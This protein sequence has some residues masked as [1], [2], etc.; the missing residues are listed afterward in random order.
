MFPDKYEIGMSHQGVKI[1]YHLL[2]KIEGVNVE[3]A[4]L[5]D[6]RSKDIFL[7][8]KIPL[9]SLE[10]RKYLKDFDL[11]GFSILS[12]LSFTNILLTLELSGIPLKTS[13]RG[14]KFPVIAIGGISAAANPEPVRD[15]VD[16][17][18]IGDGEVLF[19]E[20][21]QVLKE[22]KK[23]KTGRDLTYFDKL[24]GIYVPSLYPLK[25]MGRFYAPEVLSGTIKKRIIKNLDNSFKNIGMIVPLTEVVFNRLET[26][27][28]RG[29]PQNC[30]F[31]QAKAYYSPFRIKESQEIKKEYEEQILKTGF[32]SMSL[33]SL[34]SGDHP[35]IDKLVRD[36]VSLPGPC[37]SV[38]LPSLRPSTLSESML[39]S[40][41][42]F[43]KTGITIVPEAGSP[44]LR[45]VVNKNVTDEEILEAVKKLISSG[46]QKIKL[47]FMLGLPSETDEDIAGI[48]VLVETIL[49]ISKELKKWIKINLSFSPFIPK[50]HTAFQWAGRERSEVIFK[51]IEF[52]KEN[53][54][55]F[56]NVKFDFHGINKGVVETILARGDGRVGDLIFDAFRAGEIFT[57][58]D[59]KFNYSIWESLIKKYD[60]EI[61][62]EEIPVK[63]VLPWD[64]IELGFKRSY[65]ESEYKR[66][67][68][69]I[70][71]LSCLDMK[72]SECNGCN[73]KFNKFPKKVYINDVES[74]KHI[75]NQEE[76]KRIRIFYK[77][78]NE[79]RYF[80][81]LSMMK[82]IERI[83]RKTG[84]PFRCTEGHHPRI[85]MAS[86]P[87][88]PVFASGENEVVELFISKNV[89]LE[90]LLKELQ[91]Q[92]EH[93][94][95]NNVTEVKENKKKLTK[96]IVYTIY[97]YA[98]K[99]IKEDREI[100][101]RLADEKDTVVFGDW[102][103]E[104]RIYYPL[105]GTERFAKM[106]RIIDPDRVKCM[107]LRRIEFVFES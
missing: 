55:H 79:F 26:E 1:L 60:L 61:F 2:G 70:E 9:F 76:F 81:H 10:N 88:L 66:S 25:K 103:S 100:I 92:S 42:K 7:E 95:F 45:R 71:T 84:I 48:L 44:R 73:Y 87:P 38:S 32:E 11:I 30:R 19:P 68:N 20:I 46:W 17:V 99:I 35:D 33:S 93:L 27:I 59:M 82:Y 105:K 83:I 18:A 16:I 23:N 75:L 86:P 102:K 64:H 106:Y 58:W 4:F 54:K 14:D 36:A 37:I 24:E 6:R 62:L 39:S 94:I 85:K 65:L 47:Y 34:S 63:E 3:R 96:S 41:S 28:A 8:E 40:I 21:I 67:K 53:L 101:K 80:A 50:P 13:D 12:E 78:N 69:E 90:K 31:C 91:K 77:K 22:I 5:P 104:F 49:N 57:A 98:G 15:F 43:R 52:L 97:E 74:N 89:S 29:C 72:C 51:R 107:N 56:K